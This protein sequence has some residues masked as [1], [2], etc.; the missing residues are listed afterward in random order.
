MK[1]PVAAYAE[2]PEEFCCL[3]EYARK[4]KKLPDG[5]PWLDP[6]EKFYEK[7]MRRYNNP[8]AIN[9]EAPNYVG[10]WCYKDYYGERYSKIPAC[11]F[12]DAVGHPMEA[13]VD[14]D[15]TDFL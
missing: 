15:L 2:T 9:F 8:P 12:L 11:D 5:E 10:G 3:V 6:P 7:N 4:F 1:Y 14:V 13:D